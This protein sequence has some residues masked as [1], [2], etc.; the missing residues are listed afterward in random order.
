[1]PPA[2]GR[3]VA[4]SPATPARP[5]SVRES[6]R[7]RPDDVDPRR[8]R[9]RRGGPG[10]DDAKLEIS[11]RWAEKPRGPGRRLLG[12]LGTDRGSRPSR[13]AR[14]SACGHRAAPDRGPR[15]TRCIFGTVSTISTIST[16]RTFVAF[17]IFSIVAIFAA[18]SAFRTRRIICSRYSRG[19]RR[20]RIFS[21]RSAAPRFCRQPESANRNRRA[22]L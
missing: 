14:T 12:M 8:K 22:A 11:S 18:F 20:A 4:S 10:A 19:V 17:R 3:G 1:M 16:G 5:P 2:A 9:G 13:C 6:K 21:R 7:N 15:R